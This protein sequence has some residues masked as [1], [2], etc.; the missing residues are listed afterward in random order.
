VAGQV[1]SGISQQYVVGSA[2]WLL[3][4]KRQE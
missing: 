2:V 4:A 1:L 3:A